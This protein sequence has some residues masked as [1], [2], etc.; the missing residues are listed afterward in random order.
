MLKKILNYWLPP[1]LW[2]GF[3]FY[4]SSQPNLKSGLEYDFYLRKTAHIFEYF[5]LTFFI[6]RTFKFHN[7]A[8][9]KA[10]GFSI[11]IAFLYAL[12]DEWHQT[13]VF[14]R[15]GKLSDALIDAVGILLYLV[16]NRLKNFGVFRSHV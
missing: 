14:G 8:N 10:I 16:H 2:A 11:A 9:K 15:E 13:F 4:L 12:S 5:V 1:F 6:Y 3:I 7:F